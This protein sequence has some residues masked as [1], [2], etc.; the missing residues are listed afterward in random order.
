ML[1]KML[2]YWEI[3]SNFEIGNNYKESFQGNGN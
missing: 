1:E 3:H 2:K